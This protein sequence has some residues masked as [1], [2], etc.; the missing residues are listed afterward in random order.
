MKKKVLITG[1]SGFVGY[2]LIVEALQ[3]GLEVCAAVRP[4]SKVDHLK[5]LNIRYVHLN[6][7]SV[8]DLQTE[9]DKEQYQYV[10]HAAGITK[11]KTLDVYNQINAEFSRNLAI[12]AANAQ[13]P[14]EKFVFVSSLAAIGPLS[15]L[16]LLIQD[17]SSPNP[18]TS[19]GKSKL[20]AEQ[21]LLSIPNLPLV[22]IR[23]TAVYGPRE[24][25]LFVIFKTISKGLDPQIGR[26][27]QQLSFVYVKDL[28]AAL[29]SALELQA[30]QQVYNVSDG[31]IYSRYAL[32]EAAT[33]ILK[34]KVLRIH[35][36][37]SLVSFLAVCMEQLYV[38]R[39]DTPVL[40]KEKMNEL[41]AINWACDTNRIQKDLSF[42]PRYNLEQGLL[43]TFNWYKDNKWL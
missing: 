24:R 33:R 29:I 10:I 20:L 5:H 15:D 36:P 25:D 2:H 8:E 27:I 28:A 30:S 31:N 19:Y 4:D 9:I 26:F 16:N 14:I 6:Y 32:A 12:A 23:P 21:Y 13:V 11:A 7:N 22:I 43:E 41:T 34:K 42:T 1:A 17:D 18:V 35:L 38:K 3:K 40:N 39:K 37:L